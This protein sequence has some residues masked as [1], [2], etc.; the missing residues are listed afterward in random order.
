MPGHNAHKVCLHILQRTF[1]VIN[2]F[3]VIHHFVGRG[4]SFKVY[5]VKLWL[6]KPFVINE[7]N[8]EKK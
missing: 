6:V 7:V 2:V 3:S 1:L 5:T 8:R 4:S